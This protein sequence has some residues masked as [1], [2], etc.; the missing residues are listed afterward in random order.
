MAFLNKFRTRIK[1]V[2]LESVP[3][4]PRNIL[5]LITVFMVVVSTGSSGF[6]QTQEPYEF[7]EYSPVDEITKVLN[8]YS[9]YMPEERILF[10]YV[11]TILGYEFDLNNPEWTEDNIEGV[12]DFQ[13]DSG[14][15]VDGMIG[16]ET[17]NAMVI[18]LGMLDELGDKQD[19]SLA[20]Q[21]QT[22]RMKILR[23][24]KSSIRVGDIIK[25]FH[26][27]LGQFR[28]ARVYR[29]SGNNVTIY[30]RDRDEYF[31]LDKDKIK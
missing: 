19:L 6:G 22:D 26:F 16:P 15:K 30:D 14:I 5:W 27:E 24:N 7:P 23:R 11:L 4:L 21:Q 29:I 17:L 18:S 10:K 8:Y 13:R 31:T 25:Y 2:S 20:H 9:L 3:I 28:Y 1:V 12:K